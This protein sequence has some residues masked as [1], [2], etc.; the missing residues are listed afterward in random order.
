MQW[1]PATAEPGFGPKFCRG[2]DLFHTKWYFIIEKYQPLKQAREIKR[3]DPLRSKEPMDRE[4]LLSTS[5]VFFY[6]RSEIVTSMDDPDV[7]VLR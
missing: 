1:A 3:S 7:N 4:G 6:P 5:S 2:T